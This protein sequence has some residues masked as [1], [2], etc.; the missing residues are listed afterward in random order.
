MCNYISWDVYTWLIVV[1]RF[2]PHIYIH[3]YRVPYQRSII[4]SGVLNGDEGATAFDG[5]V[6]AG[7]YSA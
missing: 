1:D 2:R 4:Q 3:I 7:L 5:L 6:G